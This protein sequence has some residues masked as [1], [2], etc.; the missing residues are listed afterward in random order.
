MRKLPSLLL[1]VGFFFLNPGFACAPEDEYQYGAV[2]MRA[3]IEGDWA[4]TIT[5]T[6][7]AAME[8]V[9]NLKQASGAN[10]A[11]ARPARR[12]LVRSAHA[13]GART[14][15]A[16]AAACESYSEMPL[17]VTFKEG[18]TPATGAQS[19]IYRV[20]SLVFTTGDLD[21]PIGQHHVSAQIKTDGTVSSASLAPNTAGTATLRRLP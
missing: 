16:S 6:G 4:V 1:L 15:V 11:A 9:V 3:A 14:L 18:G 7:G 21:L 17:T 20:W 2:E 19:G 8:Y 10:P 13:C 5:P 12:A